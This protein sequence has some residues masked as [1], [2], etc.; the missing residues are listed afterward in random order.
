MLK[1]FVIKPNDAEQRIDKFLSKAVPGF[2]R[3]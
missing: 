3:L 1:S 2:P